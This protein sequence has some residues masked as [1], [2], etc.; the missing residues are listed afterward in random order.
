MLCEVWSLLLHLQGLLC[1]ILQPVNSVDPI[2]ILNI[3]LKRFKKHFKGWGYNLFG[4]MRKR[5]NDLKQ[6]LVDL[7][8]KEEHEPLSPDKFVRKT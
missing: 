5:K 6:D 7:E 4:H 2:D 8:S 1:I 3:K